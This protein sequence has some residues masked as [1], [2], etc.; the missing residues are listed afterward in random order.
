[1]TGSIKKTDK[2]DTKTIFIVVL[3]D[4]MICNRKT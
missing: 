3:Y 1:M 4:K 2:S